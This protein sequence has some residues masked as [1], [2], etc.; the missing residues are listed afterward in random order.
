MKPGPVVQSVSVTLR[1]LT[2]LTLLLAT[3]WLCSGIRRVPP[4][5][6]AVLF[7]FGQ[8][9][10]VQDAG[11]LLAL[12]PP[13]ETL[14]ILPGPARQISQTVA[15]LPRSPGLDD[16]Y[17][18]AAGVPMQGAAGSYLTGDGN[19][20]LLDAVLTWHIADPAA[21]AVLRD[22]VAVALDRL[23]RATAISVA[24]RA[25]LNDFIVVQGGTDDDAQAARRQQ[26][27]DA[28]L[29]GMNAR[30]DRLGAP[31][32]VTVDRIDLTAALPPQA[33]L[34]FDAL[35]VA[36]QVADQG[37]AAANTTALRLRQEAVRE[38]RRVLDAAHAAAAERV[39][40][41][42]SEVSPVLALETAGA[43]PA[44]AGLL[45]DAYR[46]RAARI[47]HRAGSVLAVDPSGGNRLILPAPQ[48]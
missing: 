18:Q 11:L 33:K 25:A 10:R 16:I 29:A 8:I 23:F 15:A 2:G 44:R 46:S 9:V 47:L 45:L 5:S 1:A 36:E 17:T 6:S 39:S 19:A 22:H 21:Y 14:A 41:A 32:G 43:S 7:R 31:L 37:I 42:T 4:D 20:V 13:F 48:P 26:M 27:R 24:G 38:T 30:L 12:P 28:L 35:L 40:A 3:V 34:A